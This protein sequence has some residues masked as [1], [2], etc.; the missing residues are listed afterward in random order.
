MAGK[1]SSDPNVFI[2]PD[3]GE[4]IARIEKDV[5]QKKEELR[6][7][8]DAD[9]SLDEE[10]RENK[11]MNDSKLRASATCESPIEQLSSITNSTSAARLDT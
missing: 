2:L 4:E 1:V 5:Q 3:L 7:E 11:W 8:L 6:D 9:E 10:K